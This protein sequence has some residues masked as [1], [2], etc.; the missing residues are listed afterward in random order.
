MVN[1]KLNIAQSVSLL[2][3]IDNEL[4]KINEELALVR[5]TLSMTQP[6]CTFARC[7]INSKLTILNN[8]FILET[9]VIHQKVVDKFLL[10]CQP[11]STEKVS[12]LHMRQGTNYNATMVLDSGE[13][14]TEQQLLSPEFCNEKTQ[15]IKLEWLLAGPETR[16]MQSGNNQ[17]TCLSAF[18]ITKKTKKHDLTFHCKPTEVIN[19]D[20]QWTLEIGSIT[21]DHTKKMK[22][23]H[24]KPIDWEDTA[25]WTENIFIQDP[26]A[27]VFLK[28]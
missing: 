21:I 25:T 18:P 16:L 13:R 19:I 24:L 10:L 14:I 20:D 9:D 26:E 27:Q 7:I 5:R 15:Y 2:C 4:Q 23:H 1:S 28:F 17:L 12:Y 6:D 11:V 22:T 3:R 8:T